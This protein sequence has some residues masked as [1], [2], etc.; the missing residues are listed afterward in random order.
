MCI[1][2]RSGYTATMSNITYANVTG[3]GASA[4]EA[5]NNQQTLGTNVSKTVTG[6]SI[7]FEAT[8][9]NV[10]GSLDVLYATV[11]LTGRDTGARIQIPFELR[12]SAGMQ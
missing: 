12:K 6:N 3:G 11:T 4:N 5:L 9:I 7:T 8:S 2:D 10:F 1:R